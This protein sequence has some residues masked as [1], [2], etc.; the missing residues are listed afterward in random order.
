[1]NL[2]TSDKRHRASSRASR[3]EGVTELQRSAWPQLPCLGRG[4]TGD[5]S[6]GPWPSWPR[7]RDHDMHNPGVRVSGVPGA[8]VD[9]V[10]FMGARRS[11]ILI[12]VGVY[13][14]VVLRCSYSLHLTP[15]NKFRLG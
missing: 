3:D 8:L 14:S 12:P 13:L 10:M 6:T 1:M 11:C 9:D 4:R 15:D 7:T 5:A 2:H